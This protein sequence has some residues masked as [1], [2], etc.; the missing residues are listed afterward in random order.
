MD[1]I[2]KLGILAVKKLKTFIDTYFIKY[3]GKKNLYG[4][5]SFVEAKEKGYVETLFIEDV[6]CR[7]K[8]RAISIYARLQKE[9]AMNYHL[10]KGKCCWYY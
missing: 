7:I 2:K 5:T 8:I 1:F 3:Q 10:F 9:R 4:K 6:T